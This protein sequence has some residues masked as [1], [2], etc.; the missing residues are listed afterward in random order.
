MKRPAGARAL[1]L[2]L[3]AGGKIEGVLRGASGTAAP[4]R[5][6]IVLDGLVHGTAEVETGPRGTARFS[7]TLPRHLIFAELDVLALP[8][9]ISL[10]GLQ[11]D[12]A[13]AYNLTVTDAT[14]DGTTIFGSFTA[15]P[16]LDPEIGIEWCD[17]L[18]VH[19]RSVA[20]RDGGVPPSWHFT[21]PLHTLLRPHETLSLHPRIGGLHLPAPL[22][23]V[24]APALGLLGCLDTASPHHAEGWAIDQRAPGRP[25]QLEVLVNAQLVA[26]ILA[27]QMRPD[28]AALGLSDG[29]CGFT[30][31]LPEHPDRTARRQIAVRVAGLGTAL[32]GS[33]LII[34]PVPGLSGS[35]DT[36]H[37]MSAHG[38]ALNRAQPEVPVQVEVVGPGDEI[39]GAGAANQFRGDLLDAGLN[40]GHCAF[41]IDISAHF[42]RLMDQDLLVRIAGTNQILPGSPQRI[43]TNANIRRLRQRRQTLRPGVLPRLRR[44]LNHRAGTGGISF[45]M[46]VHNT[47]RAWLI[48]AL[49]SVRAQFCDAWELICIDDASTAPHVAEILAGYAAREPRVR[50]LRSP[51]NVGIARAVNFGLRAA[52]YPYVAFMDHDDR[53]EPDAA[54]QLVRAARETDADLLYSDE[55][56]TAENIDAITELRLRPAFSHDYYLSHPY[57][58]HIVCARTDIARRIGGWDERLAISADVDFVLRMIEASHIVTHVPA[59]LYRWRTHGGSTGHAKQDQVM[60]ATIGALQRHLDRLHTGAVASAGVWFNQFRIDWPA[61]DGLILIVIPTKNRVELLR[62]AVESIERTAAPG[63]YRLVVIDHESDDPATRAYLADIAGRHIVMPYGGVFNFSRMNNLAVAQHGEGADFVLFLNNDIEA[64]QDGWL[65]RMRRLANRPD[66]GAV[67][68]LLMYADKTVQHAGVVMGFND[69]ADHALKFQ[70]VYLNAEGRRNLGYN[71]A[72]TSTRDYSAVTAACLMLRRAVFDQ[73]GGFDEDFGIGF[74]DTDL[75]M[76]IRQAGFRILY[77]GTT[78]LYHYESATRSQTKQVFHPEDT[79]LMITRWGEALRAGDPFYNPNLSLKTQDHV[80]REDK[81]CRVIN[82]PRATRLELSKLKRK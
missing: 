57:F 55:A 10:L 3:L 81:T 77:D 48:E 1:Q 38:W 71:C 44:A 35:F 72:L 34:D 2:S 67:G 68:A 5:I 82:R 40:G 49:E 65:D 62:T 56:Q 15:S 17:G 73:V 30:V 23:S 27:D 18:A 51:Q 16:F 9:G 50:V 37:G 14:L 19:A 25:V 21:S 78:V 33:P 46:P 74:N 63:S 26:T 54:W 41:K 70:N 31:E 60:A 36:I 80:P 43:F 22:I 29:Q 7:T 13:D 32:A 58:V 64:T 20:L 79:L 39:L 28:I 42:D 45:I 8:G 11:R 24:S 69:S 6:A 61:S 12:L 76:R 75:C 53:L 66:V 59:V 52:K 47:P 4:T